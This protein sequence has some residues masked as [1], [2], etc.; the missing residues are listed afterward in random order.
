[1]ASPAEGWR[2]VSLQGDSKGV[3]RVAGEVT[4]LWETPTGELEEQLD[5]QLAGSEVSAPAGA[6]AVTVIDAYGN[7]GSLSLI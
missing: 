1:M 2:L 3:S 6:T 5:L 4:L 7:Q